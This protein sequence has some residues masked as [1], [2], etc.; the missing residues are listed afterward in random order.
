MQFLKKTQHTPY[1]ASSSYIIR[2]NKIMATQRKG[3]GKF[4]L[5]L[6][7][8][9]TTHTPSYQD[10]LTDDAARQTCLL[11]KE[12]YLPTPPAR[13]QCILLAPLTLI[14]AL[15]LTCGWNNTTLVLELRALLVW[16]YSFPLFALVSLLTA[17]LLELK[18]KTTA[19]TPRSPDLWT[20]WMDLYNVC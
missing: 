13:S 19:Q 12:N 16:F 7:L 5:S 20:I 10:H 15:L 4:P 18:K 6:C 17:F 3:H 11:K 9:W 2:K 1:L 8:L 14:L